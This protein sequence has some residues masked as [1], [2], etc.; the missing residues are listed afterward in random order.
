ME[1]SLRAFLDLLASNNM[2]EVVE[3][4]VSLDLELANV[5]KNKQ[6]KKALVFK[7]VGKEKLRVAT[8]L[9]DTR[10]KLSMAL[11]ARNDEELFKSLLFAMNNPSKPVVKD[12]EADCYR[13]LESLQE[14]PVVRHYKE[15]AGPYITAGVV[16]ARDPDLDFQ[17]ASIHRLLV[18]GKRRL[19]IRL[20]PRHLY[21][22]YKKH[23]ERGED[24]PITIVIGLHPAL[25]LAA[26]SSP[27]YG[28]DEMQV[29]NTLMRGMEASPSP[30]H[31]HIVPRAC[32]VIIEAEIL[33]DALDDEGPFVDITGTLDGIRK[34]PV[35]EVKR[36][37]ARRDGFIFHD[38]LPAGFEH[39]LLMGVPK[40]AAIWD[41]VSKVVPKVH[42]VRLLREGCSWLIAAISISKHVDGDAKNAILAAFAAHPSLKVAIVVDEDVD[43]DNPS[44]I[45]WA[46][47]TRF[48][49]HEDLV[50]VPNARGSSL[51]PSAEKGSLATTNVGI[52]ATIPL[53]KNRGEFLKVV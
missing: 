13:S 18:K 33:H 38:I 26:S 17:N 32:E 19:V 50:L 29:A 6:G 35:V 5:A 39:Q 42:K 23:A 48:Q 53:S 10:E 14:L 21:K 12:F 43:V 16:I 49:A 28:V 30:I 51:D 8:N 40:E 3:E 9:C 41:G 20:V 47:A 2:L 37:F 7:N 45:L 15:E 46:M 11:G 36:I 25:L 34:Q 27:A 31:G 24:T 4:P 44:E 1:M 22:I 52:D